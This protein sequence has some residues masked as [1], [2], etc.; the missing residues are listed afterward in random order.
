MASTRRRATIAPHERN[1]TCK[2]K[3]GEPLNLP[4]IDQPRE[5]NTQYTPQEC[6]QTLPSLA[7]LPPEEPAKNYPLHQEAAQQLE[8]QP[9]S[10]HQPTW[11]PNLI[12]IIRTT[13][14]TPCNCPSPPE[15]SFTFNLES[16]K[17]NYIILMKKH[18]GSLQR[19]LDAN[20]K[21]PLG[22]GSEF[23]KILTIKVIFMHH[24]IW[25]QMKRILTDGLHWPLEELNKNQQMADVDKAIK[26]G[27][28]KGATNNPVPLQELVE[29]DVKCNY[30][31]PLHL[32]KAKLI[33][34][35][36]FAPMNIRHQNTIDKMGK[37]VN[38]ERLTHDQSHKWGG[39]GMSVNSRTI[40]E[41]LMPC[42]YGTCLK[43][44]IN[45]TIAARRNIPTG[46]SWLARLIL[47]QPSDGATYQQQQQSNAAPNSPSKN[48]SYCTS[49][50]HLEDP[51]AQT[52]GGP[53]QNPSAT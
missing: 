10:T 52:N 53:S 18:R 27:N 47:S 17:K 49:I 6:H 25:P 13:T 9:H 36:L 7:C 1:Q 29:K 3:L 37:I 40:K 38:K 45:W 46:G 35:L 30:C 12:K 28:H 34:N 19:A 11:P 14:S 44:L 24:P 5:R 16:A 31:I 4:E 41:L 22:M 21:T 33:S 43:R 32:Q 42:M 50:S 20:S 39:S 15:F 2:K 48:S 8:Q 26:F 23:M 51:H